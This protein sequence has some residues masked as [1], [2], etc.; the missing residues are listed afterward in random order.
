M[1]QHDMDV[2]VSKDLEVIQFYFI[3]FNG[4]PF[5]EE[6]PVGKLLKKNICSYFKYQILIFNFCSCRTSTIV[7]LWLRL[8]NSLGAGGPVA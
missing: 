8:H 2:D 7:S 6:N 4:I 1:T 5:I 3:C